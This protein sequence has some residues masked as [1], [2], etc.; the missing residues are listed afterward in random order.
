MLRP[1]SFLVIFTIREGVSMI[2]WIS[3]IASIMAF[4]S[5]AFLLAAAYIS[6]Q[7]TLESFLF[8]TDLTDV[9]KESRNSHVQSKNLQNR[10]IFFEAILAVL[11]G[12]LVLE[13]IVT[14]ISVWLI[15]ASDSVS[16]FTSKQ[17]SITLDS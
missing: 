13:V 7:E 4:Y 8:G 11:G 1:T 15:Q 14:I 3:L 2:G 9:T 6:S 5:N 12:G 17:F 10:S 16:G